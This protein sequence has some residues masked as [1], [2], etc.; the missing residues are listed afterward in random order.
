MC[1]P[2]LV[3]THRTRMEGGAEGTTSSDVAESVAA[4]SACDTHTHTGCHLRGRGASSEPCETGKVPM[5][6]RVIDKGRW[7]TDAARL[8][9]GHGRHAGG[10]SPHSA[11]VAAAHEA[12]A[13]EGSW[14]DL[15]G[16][17]LENIVAQCAGISDAP[18]VC[19][20]VTHHRTSSGGVVSCGALVSTLV[21]V[22]CGW[23]WAHF[24]V[25]HGLRHVVCRHGPCVG[26]FSPLQAIGRD[27]TR[28]THCKASPADLPDVATGSL[29]RHGHR[30]RHL[31][32]LRRGAHPRHRISLCVGDRE[33]VVGAVRG[34]RGHV[35]R[36]RPLALADSQSVMLPPWDF[37]PLACKALHC[38]GGWGS[39]DVVGIV[40]AATWPVP[41]TSSRA[42]V[43]AALRPT[44]VKPDWQEL[45]V[46]RFSR[47]PPMGSFCV[48][49]GRR[50]LSRV[51]AGRL[52]RLR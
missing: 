25:G 13:D 46:H 41:G 15:G 6:G 4:L 5:R 14:N 38:L 36:V 40:A 12:E 47:V 2:G 21:V 28:V 42:R 44:F 52:W 20:C 24:S 43:Q 16:L 17:V 35:H 11:W 22:V 39:P 51:V 50:R 3:A 31:H 49:A 18:R 32:R 9:E 23:R 34:M 10:P 19:V 45:F 1:W 48:V 7:T 8:A 30:G 33:S 27:Q 37:E 26:R 29:S